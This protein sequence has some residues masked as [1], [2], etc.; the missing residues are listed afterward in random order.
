MWKLIANITALAF[1]LAP[2]AQA[3]S[4]NETPATPIRQTPPAYPEKCFVNVDDENTTHSVT[5]TYDVTRDGMPENVRVRESTD[6]CFNDVAVAAVRSWVF[7]PR[8]VDGSRQPQTEMESTFKFVFDAQTQV[9]DFDARPRLRVP[10]RYPD[11]CQ[12]RG[13]STRIK[14]ADK[15]EIVLVEFDITPDGRTD[16]IKVIDSTNSCFDASARESV[17]QWRYDPKIVDGEPAFRRGVQAQIKYVLGTGA[18]DPEDRMRRIVV[19]KLNKANKYIQ[20]DPERAL[21]ELEEIESKYGDDFTAAESAA[22]HQVRGY[23]RIKIGDYRSALDDLRFAR[24]RPVSPE[25]T[26]AIEKAIYFLEEEIARQERE[27]AAQE[28]LGEETGAAGDSTPE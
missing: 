7:E 10:P 26:E 24:G 15:E 23:A 2:S 22:F 21:A 27:A 1:F 20:T 4:D 8:T 6:E 5:V 3:Q 19:R 18:A 17:E 28:K 13:S 11:K 12:G 14:S 16:N 9:A 25:T